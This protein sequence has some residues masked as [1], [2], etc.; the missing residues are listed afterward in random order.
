MTVALTGCAGIQN[1]GLD[2]RYAGNGGGASPAYDQFAI[3][4]QDIWLKRTNG[5]IGVGPSNG[6][7]PGFGE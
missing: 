4:E 5:Y 1:D 2:W 7:G 6:L 3:T